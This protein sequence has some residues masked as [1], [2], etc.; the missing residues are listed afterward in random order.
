M[1]R[2]GDC[3]MIAR[4]ASSNSTSIVLAKPGSNTAPS[5]ITSSA[6]R[7]SGTLS[8]RSAVNLRHSFRVVK[9]HTEGVT[10][11]GADPAYAMPEINAI[12]SARPPDRPEM[13]SERYRVALRE[14]HHFGPRLHA[15]ALL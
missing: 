1:W 11:T 13:H 4:S 6:G 10:M 3:S 5:A 15:R 14:R 12:V 7:K 2:N 8:S 9:D